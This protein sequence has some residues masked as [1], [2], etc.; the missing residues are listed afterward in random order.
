MNELFILIALNNGNYKLIL[1]NKNEMTCNSN[2]SYLNIMH[3][4]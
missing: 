4:F 2:I 3:Q 1:I